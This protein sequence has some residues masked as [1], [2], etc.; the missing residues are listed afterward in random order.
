MD[1]HDPAL[2][3]GAVLELAPF[4]LTAVIGSVAARVGRRTPQVQLA[5]LFIVLY[6]LSRPGREDEV[7][8]RR[9]IASSRRSPA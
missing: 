3:L 7:L 5:P 6:L 1:R 2:A 4:A 8:R 9:L